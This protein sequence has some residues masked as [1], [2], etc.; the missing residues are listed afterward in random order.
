MGGQLSRERP[1]ALLYQKLLT[2]RPKQAD[3][4]F[5]TS[6]WELAPPRSEEFI[7]DPKLLNEIATKAPHDFVTLVLLCVQH[8]KMLKDADSS[9]L[10]PEQ[11]LGQLSWGLVLFTSACEVLMTNPTLF[12]LLERVDTGLARQYA[13]ANPDIE[14]ALRIANNERKK[15]KQLQ[16]EAKHQIPE[17]EPKEEKKKAPKRGQETEARPQSPQ[18]KKVTQNPVQNEVKPSESAQARPQ[19]GQAKKVQRRQAQQ[20]AEAKETPTKPAQN[21]EGKQARSKSPEANKAQQTEGKPR[22]ATKKA[23]QARPKSP[24]AVKPQQAEG[25]PQNPDAKKLA[26]KQPQQAEPKPKTPQAKKA[27]PAQGQVQ[28]PEV[29]KAEPRP[30]SPAVKQEAP[31]PKNPSAKK[32]AQ[33]VEAKPKTPETVK[34]QKE[35]V[36][37]KKGA[38]KQ[39]QQAEAKPKTPETV[40][41]QQAAGKPKNPEAKNAPPKQAESRPKSPHVKKQPVEAAPQNPEV[42]KAPAKAP[43]QAK[44]QS[45]KAKKPKQADAKAQQPEPKSAQKPP[46]QP[47]E[48]PAEP[49]SV[50]AKKA[51]A[52]EPQRP[53]SRNQ[54]QKKDAP[55][56]NPEAPSEPI[57][58]KPKTPKQ[59][60]AELLHATKPNQGK[61]VQVLIETLCQSLFKHGLTLEGKETFWAETTAESETVNR[62]R[63]DIVHALL[64]ATSLN[65][66]VTHGVRPPFVCDM[67]SFPSVVFIESTCAVATRYLQIVFSGSKDPTTCDLLRNCLTLATRIF[68]DNVDFREAFKNVKSGT[69]IKAFT[70]GPKNVPLFDP[71]SELVSEALSFF[72]MCSLCQPALV[73]R[74]AKGGYATK[75]IFSLVHGAQLAFEKLNFSYHQSIILSTVLL[76]VAK[77]AIAESLNEEYTD[78]FQAQYKPLKGSHADLLMNVLLNI[79]DRENFYE[80]V[81]SVFHMLAPHVKNFSN[82]TAHRV[83][84]L[85]KTV[86]NTR[87]D[88][89]PLFIEAFASIVQRQDN[90]GN[91]FL[92]YLV[93][94]HGTFKRLELDDPKMARA[95]PVLRKYLKA[96][97]KAVKATQ[98]AQISGEELLPILA[99]VKLE[100]EPV[101]FGSHPH[102]FGGEM[103]KTWVE[104]ADLLFVKA[105]PRELELIRPLQE[106]VAPRV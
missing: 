64:G 19:S 53:K 25:K 10:F 39:M 88:L 106:S 32:A 54:A 87:K 55:K 85:F 22:K 94:N 48:K 29:K 92:V 96:A 1:D 45:P 58:F 79:F 104:W 42:Q 59:M 26:P 100:Q 101:K 33:Q 65:Y 16:N 67:S 46:Q 57:Q 90:S 72:Y 82:K 47:N 83:M 105:F 17:E 77:P 7:P 34:V 50:T 2:E 93:Q 24:E 89:V 91:H 51:P 6:I 44:P 15:A 63:R 73:T 60:E 38:Q 9:Q 70:L 52:Q 35:G 20:G 21:V 75:F 3:A 56:P 14:E 99:E 49:A 28:N 43:Q 66:F 76:L 68:S 102:A 74:V 97:I 78:A 13:N 12:A 84:E 98:K 4:G 36:K 71:S 80:A 18:T 61:C 37:A 8:V 86:L 62:T 40:K 5:W 41:A 69:L 27:Q 95:L 11:V 31:K 30:K 23:Q 81:V 103:E